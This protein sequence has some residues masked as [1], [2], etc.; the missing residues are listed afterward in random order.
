AN[1]LYVTSNAFA[2]ET[3]RRSI[4]LRL[5]LDTLTSRGSLQYQ[6]WSST[7]NF[8]LRCARGAGTVMHFASHNS[9]NQIRLFTWPEANAGPT[10][11]DVNV[12]A[13]DAGLYS[14]PGPDGTNWLGR[15]DPR[16]TG[17]WIATGRIG[18]A[19]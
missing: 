18:L 6:Y 4:V 8:A 15:C 17:A 2:G 10:F 11:R 5:P 13:W 1:H 3:W 9:L 7:R 19:W 14:A 16:I 12:T